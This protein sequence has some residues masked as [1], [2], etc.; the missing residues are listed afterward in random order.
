MTTATN[1]FDT[2]LENIRLP[3]EL[4]DA[5]RDAHHDL[6]RRLLADASLSPLFVSMFVQG[7]YARHTGTKPNGDDTHV[8]VDLVVVTSLDP[9]AF[10]PDAVVELFRPFLD[11]N[12]PNT[13]DYPTHWE[14]QDRAIKISPKG[15][16]VTLDLVVT[17]A[18]SEVQQEFFRSFRESGI[19][20]LEIEAR[21]DRDA[22]RVTFREAFERATKAFG[23]GWQKD[24]LLIPS[25]DLRIWVPTHPIEQIRWTTDKNRR[26]NGHYVDVVKAGRWWR[27]LNP[28]GEYPRSYPLEHFI[29]DMCPD[30]IV[31]VA[32][33]VTRVFEL[34][35]ETQQPWNFSR[36]VPTL[37]DR[38]VPANDVF[39]KITPD[40]YRTFHSLV[41]TA[42]PAARA[43]LDA[44][45]N[46][47]SVARWR[48]LLGSE[49]PAPPPT[50]FTPP[51]GPA[52]ATTS[53][54]YG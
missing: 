32:E 49:F 11:R 42:A 39:R 38:G 9:L 46:P 34:I 52:R 6:R 17:A 1:S 51:T 5:C 13:P 45:T 29:G 4:R 31:S 18:P 30:G 2:F 36:G 26:T 25:R 3:K 12:Y 41:S 24:P 10:T 40:Q 53:G 7:S 50:P 48:D 8:D 37:Q 43:A 47:E 23:E 19:P 20:E 35:A 15:E 28:E 33:G 44:D 16:P 22:Q 21:G 27:K 54:R 14:R